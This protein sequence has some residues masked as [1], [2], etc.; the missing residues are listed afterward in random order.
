MSI[1]IQGVDLFVRDVGT[2]PP[3]LFL[4]GNP[5]SADIWNDVIAHLEGRFR[6]IAIDL[7]GFGRSGAAPRFD[8]SFA[9]LGRFTGEV[10]TALAISEPITVVAHDYGGAFAM[11]WAATEPT[12]VSRLLVINHP[13]FV[14]DYPWHLWARIWRTPL[15]GELSTLVMDWWPV[16]YKA[17]KTGSKKLSDAYI[18][19]AYSLMTSATKK[20]I[21]RLY[22][23]A[24][25]E[26]FRLW[27]PRMLQATAV[28]PTLVLWGEH[29][30]Y[31]PSWVAERF[32]TSNVIRLP[33]CGHWVPAEAPVCVA[34]E[35]LRF[36]SE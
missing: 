32:G 17:L 22:R 21:L 14:A 3:V 11:A 33:A 28:I 13:F 6:C 31:I 19:Q 34:R 9:N 30:P 36:G 29:D 26:Q 8:C 20:M 18:R 4:H 25:P 35:L 1:V 7:P 16:F 12:R 23:A 10:V 27:E 2:G 24:D 15:L 5:D